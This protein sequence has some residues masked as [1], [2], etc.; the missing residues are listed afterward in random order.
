M[1]GSGRGV[2]ERGPERGLERGL[3]RGYD[4][5]PSQTRL[6]PTP[7][8]RVISPVP[9]PGLG[10]DGDG[11]GNT[12]SSY[13]P[14]GDGAAARNPPPFDPRRLPSA[15]APPVSSFSFSSGRRSALDGEDSS[16]VDLTVAPRSKSLSA[17]GRES[18]QGRRRFLGL[19]ELQARVHSEPGG[20]ALMRPLP[21]AGVRL[22]PP[23]P[24]CAQ[25][26]MAKRM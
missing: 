5:T 7:P 26:L 19:D 22:P 8:P 4:R 12:R 16:A 24:K 14:L 9:G 15:H 11:R 3:E 10:G 18:Q 13:I 17:H 1:E 23:L 20:R 2:L 6:S 21:S 25:I